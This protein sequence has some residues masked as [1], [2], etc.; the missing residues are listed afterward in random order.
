MSKALPETHETSKM[1]SFATLTI[2][3]CQNVTKYLNFLISAH[4]RTILPPGH[5][6]LIERLMYVQ[7]TS[8]VFRVHINSS[9][10]RLLPLISDTDLVKVK[11]LYSMKTKTG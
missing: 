2:R 3:Y 9:V 8:C 7:F 6:T 5:R 4:S 11:Y 1:E 10:L